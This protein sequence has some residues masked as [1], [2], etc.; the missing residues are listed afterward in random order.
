[1]IGRCVALPGNHDSLS[2]GQSSSQGGPIARSERPG[3]GFA[4]GGHDRHVRPGG[5]VG[6]A[7]TGLEAIQGVMFQFYHLRALSDNPDHR[8][9]VVGEEML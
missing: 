8:N 2:V 9:R 3:T 1:M 4:S 6:F 7:W 5:A